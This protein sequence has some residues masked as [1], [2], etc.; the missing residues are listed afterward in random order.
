[1]Q[2]N[3]ATEKNNVWL[4]YEISVGKVMEKVYL[5]LKEEKLLGNTCPACKKVLFPARSFCPE[6]QVDMS[7]WVELTGEGEVVTW[8]ISNYAFY[9][10]PAT[11]PFIVAT[12][13]LDGAD[14]NF[15]HIIHLPGVNDISEIKK[16]I[17]KGT[18][19][20]AVFDPQKNGHMLD[21]KYFAPIQ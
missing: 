12:I 6:C 9:G 2:K 16:K 10:A 5:G 15:L 8:T 21:I 11:P 20:K 13:R 3:Y 14:C 17:G 19:V 7:G 1:M 18:R 4:P